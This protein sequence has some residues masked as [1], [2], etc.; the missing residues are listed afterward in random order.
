MSSEFKSDQ[1]DAIYAS[2]G[3]SGIYE[4]PYRY[5]GY[6]PLFKR[7]TRLLKASAATSVLEVGCGTGGLAHMVAETT[8]IRYRSFDFSPVAV[9]RA[10]IRLNGSKDFFVGDARLPESY[11][12]PAEAIVCTEVLEHI[13]DDMDVI[14]N[15]PKGSYCICS[16][17]NFDADNHVRF[18]RNAEQV[19]ERYGSLLQIDIID[20]VKKPVIDDLSPT[21]FWRAVRWNRYR[22]RRLAELFGL[23][24]FEQIGGWFIF[25]GRRI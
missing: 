25:C 6:F 4:L 1:Y 17:P 12:I 11:A 22:P 9:E 3:R 24:S 14:Q 13:Q 7:V 18:F 8:Q 2:G 16:V 21:H 5:S 15:W 23:G 20:Q 10:R 19:R